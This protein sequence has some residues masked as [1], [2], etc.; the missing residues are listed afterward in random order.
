MKAEIKDTKI[1]RKNKGYHQTTEINKMDG[2][3]WYF[4][5]NKKGTY[6]TFGLEPF[7]I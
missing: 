6:I 5:Y 7:D 3:R 1:D 2:M 4:L